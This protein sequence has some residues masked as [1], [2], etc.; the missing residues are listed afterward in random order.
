MIAGCLTLATGIAGLLFLASLQPV[1]QSKTFDQWFL[2]SFN[3]VGVMMQSSP[4]PAFDFVPVDRARFLEPF[5]AMGEPAVDRLADIV[6][7]R[8]SGRYRAYKKVHSRLPGTIARRLPLPL[9]PKTTRKRAAAILVLMGTEARPAIPML[10]RHLEDRSPDVRFAAAQ[11]LWALVGPEDTNAVPV[12]TRALEDT[13][14]TTRW[15]VVRA[16]FKIEPEPTQTL[17][18]LIEALKDTDE[19]RRLYAAERLARFQSIDAPEVIPALEAACADSNSQ[20]RR[21]ANHALK[22]MLL[23]LAETEQE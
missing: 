7:R 2:S 13:D 12:L 11:T 16:L 14:P 10:L 22:A 3:G 1:Y 5:R 9:D 19:S 15:V 8:D 21:A 4:Y 17:P 18:A 20:V 23:N 6:G